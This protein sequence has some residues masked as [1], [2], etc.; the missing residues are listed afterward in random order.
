VRRLFVL[1]IALGVVLFLGV[2][3]LLARVFSAEGAERSAV[4]ALI[5]AEARGDALGVVSLL[6]GCLDRPACSARVRAVAAGLARPGKLSILQL[7]PST[8]FSLGSTTGIARVAWDTSGSSLPVVQ[9]V[10]VHRA[11]DA[12]QGLSIQLLALSARIKSDADCPSRIAPD[13]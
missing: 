9:C 5:Q 1:L 12:I 7:E 10:L 3:A 11:G 4:T 2:S 13:A 6:H 8:G